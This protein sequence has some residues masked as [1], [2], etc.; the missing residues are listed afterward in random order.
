M[1]ETQKNVKLTCINPYAENN[2]I[3]KAMRFC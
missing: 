1:H 2:K 3:V